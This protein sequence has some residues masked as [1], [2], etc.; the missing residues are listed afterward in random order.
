LPANADALEPLEDRVRESSRVL[1]ELEERLLSRLRRLQKVDSR[2]VKVV[3]RRRQYAGRRAVRQ[4]ERERNRLARELHTGVGQLLATIRVQ[5]DLIKAQLPSPPDPVVESLNRISALAGSALEEVRG[6]SK[7]FYAPEWLRLSLGEAIR[8]LVE[9]S[10]L[11]QRFGFSLDISPLS[12]DPD[13]DIKTLFY[14]TA[15]EAISNVTRHSQATEVRVVLER[16]GA[17]VRLAV[18]DNGTG[19]DVEKTLSGASGIGLRAL[20]EQAADLGGK[21][22]I[23]SGAE[24]TTLEIFVPI[25]TEERN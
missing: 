7:K 13:P 11:S 12:V 22:M 1:I 5:V 21:A 2:L 4:I 9:A 15:Q 17:G 14:R 20:R 8:E 23:R 24:G 25:E 6:I 18:Q 10:G 3:A 16:A 19:F